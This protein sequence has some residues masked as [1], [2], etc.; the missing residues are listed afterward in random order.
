MS[1]HSSDL[2]V[3]RVGKAHGLNGELKVRLTTDRVERVA[4]GAELRT[5]ETDLRVERSRPH[6]AVFIVAFEG[7]GTREEAEALRG[8]ALFATPID[9]PT[10]IWVHDLIGTELQERDGTTRGTVVAVQENP[11]SDLLVTDAGAL[12]PLTFYVEQRGNVVIIDPPR[13]LFAQQE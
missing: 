5:E 10:A 4:P 1:R 2:E 8:K 9:D 3:G 7:V 11:A 12:V 13:G 6:Q